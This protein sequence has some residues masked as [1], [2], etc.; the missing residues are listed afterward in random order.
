MSIERLFYPRGVAVVGS[1]SEGKLGLELVRQILEGGYKDL[2]AVNP[3]AQ[4]AF[5]VPGFK[6][7][8]HIN[9]PVDA[10]VIVTPPHTVAGVLEDCGRAG[11]R[12]AAII[13]AGFS[14]TGNHEGEAH[15]KRVSEKYGIR[16]IGPNCAGFL[17]TARSLY[18]T[19][20][21]R[22]PAGRVGLITQS[23][24]MGGVFLGLAKE[25]GLGVSKFVNYG[26]AADLN[27]IE[28]LRYFAD[29]P[30]TKVVGLYIESVQDGREFTAAMKTC[31]Q[32]KPLIVIK[33]GRMQSGK[34]AAL[35]HTGSLAGADVVYESAIRQSGAVRIHSIE[36]MFDLCKGFLFV[37]PPK[38]RRM[39]IVTNSGG[40]GVLAADRAEELGLEVPE[41][42]AAL[43]EELSRFLP[44]PCALGN[45]IDLTVEGTEEGYRETLRTVLKE[46]DAV[47]ALNITT[48][49]LDSMPLARGICDGAEGTE[50][51][52]VA[53]FLPRYLVSE[54][55]A[56]LEERGVPAFAT[57]ER[58]VAAVSR[59][60]EYR[61]GGPALPN[62]PLD[63]KSLPGKGRV[64][65]QEAVV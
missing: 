61:P 23:G 52:V 5:S 19:L 16:F 45:P 21:S 65:E 20:E 43:K 47:L 34:R 30:E 56:Y 28:F 25:Q 17:N 37:S 9:Q 49:Y 32:V 7:L 26:N 4:G 29:D 50:K 62:L 35:S 58:A 8:S 46:Y 10:A 36:E 60:G 27:E 14:E 31:T 1:T 6:A 63:T 55:A 54:A 39:V 22:P 53:S 57:A 2:F 59:M 13:T 12:A 64:L 15:L 51:P 24:A 40:P 42:S 48:P 41:P 3:K 33:A 11:V 44:G 38:G 18:P